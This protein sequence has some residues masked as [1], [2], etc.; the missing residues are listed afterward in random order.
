MKNIKS[1]LFLII[2]L[3]LLLSGILYL[4]IKQIPP[5][6]IIIKSQS[7]SPS[8][9]SQP[10]PNDTRTA[11]GTLVRINNNIL[12]VQISGA[13][14][15]HFIVSK[16]FDFQ[17]LVSGTPQRGDAKTV[18]AAYSDLKTGQQIL[19]IAEK[20]SNYARSVYILQ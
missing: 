13:S 15:Q 3:F 9:I 4:V 12:S 10:A 14:V 16:T 17:Q 18:P 11:Q 1:L 7:D 8:V 2:G 19:V 6:E 20:N 5:S